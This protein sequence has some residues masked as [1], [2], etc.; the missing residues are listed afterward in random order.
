MA[1]FRLVNIRASFDAPCS[2]FVMVMKM[3]EIGGKNASILID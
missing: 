1:K 3:Y 2:C